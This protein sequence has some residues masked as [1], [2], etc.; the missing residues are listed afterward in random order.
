ML[1]VAQ[2]L[3]RVGKQPPIRLFESRAPYFNLTNESR[4]PVAYKGRIY[5]TAQHVFQAMKFLPKYPD[6]VEHI[7]RCSSTDEARREVTRYRTYMRADWFSVHRGKME[8]VL[9]LKFQQHPDLCEE[10]AS[11]SNAELIYDNPSDAFWGVGPNNKGKNEFGKA[12]MR[13]RKH[14]LEQARSTR[15]PRRG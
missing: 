2:E 14:I 1:E 9:S 3:P 15:R 11:S 12:L 5:P 8:E 6:L 4:H 7:R 10:L 13:L